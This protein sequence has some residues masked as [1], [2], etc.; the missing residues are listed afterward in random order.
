[1]LA[2]AIFFMQSAE[3]TPDPSENR[4]AQFMAGVANGYNP[5]LDLKDELM[6]CFAYD[7][8]IDADADKLIAAL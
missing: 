8:K 2:A 3:N 6:E 1:M 5:D 4:P 7:A